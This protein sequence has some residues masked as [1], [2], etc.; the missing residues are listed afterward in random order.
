MPLDYTYGL[1]G[2]TTENV[3]NQESLM[4][5]DT[6]AIADQDFAITVATNPI[7]QF[8]PL[9]LS[10]GAIV[11]WV[12]GNPIYGV[13]LY[14]MPVGVQRAAIRVAGMFNIDAMR[15]PVSTT[16]AQVQ[17]AQTGMVRFRKLLY[18]DKRTGNEG[19]PGTYAGPQ[20]P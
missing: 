19:A 18:S 7:P 11:P 16:E 8:Y 4:A 20:T 2:S 6:P 17:S 1:A 5:A 9:M 14:L 13:S 15:W 12:A 10:A 3:A